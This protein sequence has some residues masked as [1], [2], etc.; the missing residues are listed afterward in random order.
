MGPDPVD[1]ILAMCLDDPVSQFDK[2]FP[3]VADISGNTESFPQ[4]GV[5]PFRPG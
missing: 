2:A 1:A 5:P 4:A 3:V